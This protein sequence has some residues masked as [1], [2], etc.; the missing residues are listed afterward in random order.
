MDHLN[1]VITAYL[2][3]YLS[4]FKTVQVTKRTGVGVL[5]LTKRKL[6]PLSL[7][8]IRTG[9]SLELEDYCKSSDVTLQCPCSPTSREKEGK[10]RGGEKQCHVFEGRSTHG[11]TGSSVR[12]LERTSET[13]LTCLQPLGPGRH[14][15]G[16][17]TLLTCYLHSWNTFT[18]TH[19]G[20]S[21]LPRGL[22]LKE[23]RFTEPDTSP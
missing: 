22:H 9:G 21:D 17:P 19:A 14:L 11:K 7:H 2:F 6:E 15:P 12:D 5:S 13:S 3:T 1:E 18:R 8:S 16:R 23:Q 20:E 4:R 10:N